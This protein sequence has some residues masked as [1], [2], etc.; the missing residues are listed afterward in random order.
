MI[1][2]EQYSLEQVLPIYP[3]STS[4]INIIKVRISFMT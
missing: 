4:K 3:L 2:L 1:Q